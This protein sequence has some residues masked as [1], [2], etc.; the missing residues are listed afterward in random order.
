MDQP[1]RELV[2]SPKAAQPI[3]PYSLGVRFDRLVFTSGQVGIDPATGELAEDGIEAETRQALK[4]LKDVLEAG[5]SSLGQVLKTTVFM[6]DMAEFPRMNA[7]Y[8]EFFTAEPPA[9]STVEVAALP[10][11]ARVEIEAV[12]IR[13][14]A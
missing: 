3:G 10:K 14:A 13:P 11:G 8:G 4:N 9:R 1:N 5:G 12:A 2:V 7:V 6:A